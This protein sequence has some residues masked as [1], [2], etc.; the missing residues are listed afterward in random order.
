[1][2]P[3]R[4]PPTPLPVHGYVQRYHVRCLPLILSNI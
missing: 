3:G 4:V 2:T 1:L